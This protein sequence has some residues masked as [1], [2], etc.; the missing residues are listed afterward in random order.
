MFDNTASSE[1]TRDALL[2]AE[3]LG[4]DGQPAADGQSRGFRKG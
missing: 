4:L 2:L 3:M 1:A